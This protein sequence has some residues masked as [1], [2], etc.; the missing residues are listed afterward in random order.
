VIAE[1]TPGQLKASVGTGTLRI[2]LLDPEQRPQAERLLTPAFE[3]IELAAD[4]AGL[5]VP[6]ADPDR[7]AEALA[8]LTAAGLGI[9]D[10]SLGQPSLDEVFL[11]LTGHPADSQESDQPSAKELAA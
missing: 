10:F 6:N 5:S 2:R 9:A 3:K 1:G 8:T 11:A 7:A 4:P